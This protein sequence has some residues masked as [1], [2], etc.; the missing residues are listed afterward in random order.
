MQRGNRNI[1]AW[2]MF[3]FLAVW[4][5][6]SEIGCAKQRCKFGKDQQDFFYNLLCLYRPTGD[7]IRNLPYE[8][9]VSCSNC[10]KGHVC[11]RRQCTKES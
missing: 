10:P 11:E 3:P 7:L 6:A 8:R 9:G 4:A 5:N 2:D 1:E